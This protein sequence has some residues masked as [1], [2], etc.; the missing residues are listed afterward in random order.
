[1]REHEITDQ[2]KSE[3][4]RVLSLED[5]VLQLNQQNDENEEELIKVKSQYTDKIHRL[6]TILQVYKISITL[7]VNVV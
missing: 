3:K 2:L 5:E 4:L 7:L 6:T 1:M